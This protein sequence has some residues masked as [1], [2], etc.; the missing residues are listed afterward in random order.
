MGE[1][2][3]NVQQTFFGG[4]TCA[5]TGRTRVSRSGLV[6]ELPVAPSVAV[7]SDVVLV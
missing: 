6:D 3:E 7:D 2:D 1:L 5:V 4:I